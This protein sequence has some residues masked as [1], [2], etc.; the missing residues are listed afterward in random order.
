MFG[1]I[2]LNTDSYKA[3]HFLQ[4]P[5]G[6]SYINS[7]I[8]ARGI[9]DDAPLK[10]LDKQE[11]VFF[12]LQAFLL[13]VLSQ[14][15]IKADVEDAQEILEA[16]GEPFNKDGWMKIVERYGG[17]LPLRIEALPEGMPVPIG[18]AMVQVNN[19]DTEL[20]WLTSYIETAMLRSVWYPSTVATISREIKK[21][22]YKNLQETSLDPDSQINFKLHDFGA[23]GV[24]SL[25]SA[26]LGG[27]AHLVNFMGTDTVA[28]LIAARHY[29]SAK[30]IA[31]F[32][33]PAAEHSTITSW[34]RENE[35][36]AYRNMLTQFG[37]PGSLVAV[38]SDSYDIYHAAEKIWGEE[39]KDEVIK[40]GA[41]VVVR[42]D[43]GNPVAVC[44]AL[45]RIL[46][47]R[48]G[49]VVNAKGYKVL[50]PAVRLIQGDG[51][52]YNSISEILSEM[53]KQGWAGDNIAFGMGGALLQKVN[54]DT[55][56]FAMKANARFDG[57]KW[58]DV[59]KSPVGDS[60]KKS[61][62]GLLAVT[63]EPDGKIVTIRK[64]NLLYSENLLQTVYL[65]GEIK[66]EWSFD[67]VRAN[68]KL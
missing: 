57:T 34:G 32:S 66:K 40:S 5:P 22:I 48:F 64:E 61:K 8:E 44:L 14:Q 65:D 19:T 13:E 10:F 53:K 23:R 18:T 67:E 38:V 24:S 16:H 3:S 60:S 29:Y 17:F 46:G 12:G 4:Y 11:I 39:L 58:H 27:V 21:V 47:D 33:I 52:D 35:S 31:G 62:S 54:R 37:K 28:A 2:I 41:T 36:K 20:P 42:P 9:A 43:S 6:T 56:K 49:F 7:Y 25:E 50:N 45:L 63:K 15:I 55:F 68:A 51:V 59:Y 1:N 26:G 30:Q